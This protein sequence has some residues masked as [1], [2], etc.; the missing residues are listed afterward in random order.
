MEEAMTLMLHAGAE[1]IGYDGLRELDVPQPTRTHVPIPHHRL[2]DLVAHSLSYYGHEVVEQHHGVTPDGNRYFGVLTLH[3]PYTGYAD[4]VGLRNSH[5]RTL[6]VGI[7]FGSRVFVCDNTAFVSDH[8]IKTKHTAKLKL[9]LPG[10]IGE[11]IEPIA[12]QREAQHKTITRYQQTYLSDMEADHVIMSLYRAGVINVTRIADV[13]K[14]WEEPSFPDF[15]ERTAWRLFNAV[16]YALTG[17]VMENPRA[18]TQLHQIIDGAC[19]AV[20]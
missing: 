14:E 5:D 12:D 13:H 18:T 2:V 16:T 1:P 19:H 4:M 20:H 8:V 15:A 11:L 10:L 7:A 6:P 3:S 17:K 9:R